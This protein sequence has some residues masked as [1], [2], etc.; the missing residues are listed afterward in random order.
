MKSWALAATAAAS[1]SASEA[2][3]FPIRMFSAM[4]PEK[5]WVSWG[6]AAMWLRTSLTEVSLMSVPS[7]VT[8]P[9]AGS[10]NRAIN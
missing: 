10:K 7:T 8:R 1:T 5:R 9:E 6:T 3:K 2:S 4:V